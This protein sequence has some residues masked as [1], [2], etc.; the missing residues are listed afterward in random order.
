MEVWKTIDYE[1]IIK[2]KYEV[3]NKGRVRNKSTLKILKGNNPDNEKGYVRVALQTYNGQRKFAVHRLVMYMFSNDKRHYLEVNHKIP[4][5]EWKSF[6]SLENLEYVTRSENA[7]HALN[8]HMYHTCE[9]HHK[10]LFTNDEVHQICKYLSEGISMNKIIKRMGFQDI[11][12]I[13]AYISRIK[14]RESWT[15]ISYLYRWDNDEIIYKTY[16]K[17]D[18]EKMCEFI[19][20]KKLKISNIIELFPHYNSKKLKN[21]LKK[22]KQRKLYKSISDKYINQDKSSTTSNNMDDYYRIVINI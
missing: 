15:E 18:I 6:N 5:Y 10:A 21:V 3:S 19:F 4:G 2:D 12:H 9:D 8:N 7:N 17:Y 20:I 13:D 22:I 11:K 16:K 1:D 14:N